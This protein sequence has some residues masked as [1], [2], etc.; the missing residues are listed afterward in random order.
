MALTIVPVAGDTVRL[1]RDIHNLVVPA[2]QLSEDDVRE[3]AARNRLT[4]AYDGDTA[5][6]N[7]TIRPP[8]PDTATVIVRILPPY[9][10]R[11]L[12]SRYLAALLTEARA[13]GSRRI[14][15]VVLAANEDG[16]AFAA[17]HGFVETGR[18]VLDGR[19]DE[20]VDLVLAP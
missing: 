18:Y 17:R 8:Q 14:E 4:L 15:T 7:G 11:G 16:L 1:W 20:W 12:G 19:A 13:L 10:R 6:G 5:V 3:R 2:H 9:R